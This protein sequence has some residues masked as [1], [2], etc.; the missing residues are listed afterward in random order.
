VSNPIVAARIRFGVSQLHRRDASHARTPV[1]EAVAVIAPIMH[2]M[3]TTPLI[4][5]PPNAYGVDPSAI[6]PA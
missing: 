1:A 4:V 5:A 6:R 2:W 3:H